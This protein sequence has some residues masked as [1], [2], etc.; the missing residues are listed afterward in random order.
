MSAA[1]TRTHV[2]DVGNMA[3][4]SP[5]AFMPSVL[6]EIEK[7]GKDDRRMHLL[8]GS[9]KEIISHSPPEVLS[10][11]SNT[12]WSPLFQLCENASAQQKSA[13]SAAGSSAR[14]GDEARL[15]GTRNIAAECLGKITLTNPSLYLGQLQVSQAVLVMCSNGLLFSAVASLLRVCGHARSGHHRHPLHFHRCFIHLR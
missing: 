8:L 6:Q 10:E 12:L 2:F 4:G 3:A 1:H 7:A 14:A 9:V 5:A 11:L 15:D 13:D